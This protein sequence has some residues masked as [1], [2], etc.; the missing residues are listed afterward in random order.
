MKKRDR[1]ALARHAVTDDLY[2]NAKKDLKLSDYTLLAIIGRKWHDPSREY[3]VNILQCK[4]ARR[5]TILT[6]WI[7]VLTVVLVVFAV[8]QNLDYIYRIINDIKYN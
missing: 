7:I 2:H 6:N 4:N 5:M 8:I 1:S 3:H